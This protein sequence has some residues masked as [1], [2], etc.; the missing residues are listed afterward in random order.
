M[1]NNDKYNNNKYNNDDDTNNNNIK[2]SI[3]LDKHTNKQTN[4]QQ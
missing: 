3:Q 1:D 2:P 4:D